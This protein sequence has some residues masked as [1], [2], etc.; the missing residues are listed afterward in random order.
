MSRTPSYLLRMY[1][2]R[3]LEERHTYL[4][5]LRLHAVSWGCDEREEELTEEIRFVA[6][7]R[8]RRRHARAT[9]R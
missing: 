9:G 4:M 6:L 5:L 3:A 8:L 7:E 2:D 1:S